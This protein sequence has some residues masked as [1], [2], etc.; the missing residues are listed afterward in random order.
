MI[1]HLANTSALTNCTYYADMTGGNQTITNTYTGIFVGTG[2]DVKVVDANG[3]DVIY[4]AQSG[5]TLALKGI[6]KIY[7]TGT[8]ALKLVVGRIE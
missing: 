1:T 4:A 7:A 3:N 6:T 8:T 5:Q 2:G